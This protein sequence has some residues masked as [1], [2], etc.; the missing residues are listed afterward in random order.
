MVAGLPPV[1]ARGLLGFHGVLGKVLEAHVAARLN[2]AKGALAVM[3]MHYVRQ[4]S[5]ETDESLL[6]LLA[7]TEITFLEAVLRDPGAL[8]GQM[9]P[10]GTVRLGNNRTHR[11]EV[12]QC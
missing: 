9:P 3:D 6:P 2:D 5:G 7:R 1:E 12:Y 11:V 10:L 8:F 4:A